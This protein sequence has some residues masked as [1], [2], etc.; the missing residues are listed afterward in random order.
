ML[1]Y[2]TLAAMHAD[3]KRPDGTSAYIRATGDVYTSK[4]G[5]WTPSANGQSYY[6]A[7]VVPLSLVATVEAVSPDGKELTLSAPAAVNTTNANVWLDCLP[8][9]VVLTQA[10]RPGAVA[11]HPPNVS[12]S[13]PAGAWRLSNIAKNTLPVGSG[14]KIYGQGRTQTTL[15]SPKGIPCGAFDIQGINVDNVSISDM[16][17]HGNLADNGFC[18]VISMS[19]NGFGGYPSAFTLHSSGA[20][21]KGLVLR[22]IDGT[23]TFERLV[24]ICG[25]APLI[26]NCTVTITSGQQDYVGWQIQ[27]YDSAGGVIQNCRATGAKLFKAFE[28]FACNGSRIVNCNGTNAL[29]ATNSSTSWT[30]D[31]CTTVIKPG[32]FFSQFSGAIDEAV[33]NVNNNAF[34][35]GSRGSI[36]NCNVIQQGYIDSR[37][38]S[39]KAIQIS[40]DQSDCTIEGQYA[41]SAGCSTTRAGIFQAPDYDPRSAEYGAMAIMSDAPRTI[42]SGIRSIGTA[43]GPRGHGSHFGNISLSGAGSRIMNCVADIVHGGDQSGNQSNSSF[44][45]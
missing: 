1:N 30:F 23:N 33:I 17:Y 37:N 40:P 28:M 14:F 41:G 44:C 34:R 19:G 8:S 31:S 20:V 35:S 15:V 6:P 9:F 10:P 22:N 5:M 2:V 38:N 11:P 36:R 3:K 18:F 42:V 26:D 32:A 12:I 45:R 43:I 27:I 39:L 29:Y 4:S 16:A 25:N 21:S 7:K 24:G 13:I